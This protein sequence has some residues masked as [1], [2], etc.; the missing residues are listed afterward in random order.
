MVTRVFKRN[1]EIITVT[2]YNEKFVEFA[3]EKKQNGTNTKKAGTLIK[4]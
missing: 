3:R 2:G 1:N 4:T